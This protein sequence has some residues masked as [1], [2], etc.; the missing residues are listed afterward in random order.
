MTMPGRKKYSKQKIINRPVL[1]TPTG[2][3]DEKRAAT[4]V[5]TDDN[6]KIAREKNRRLKSLFCSKNT[7]GLVAPNKKKA[8]TVH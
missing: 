4:E 1:R 3:A 6:R 5:F 8:G 7:G 2:T